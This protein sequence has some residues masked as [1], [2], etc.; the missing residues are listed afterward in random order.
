MP[1]CWTAGDRL[2]TRPKTALRPRRYVK[3]A[4]MRSVMW[5]RTAGTGM[6][7]CA[8]SK[9]GTGHIISGTALYVEQ[10]TPMRLEYSVRCDADWGCRA[11]SVDR[12]AGADKIE[13]RLQRDDDGHWTANGDLIADMNG[14]R[15]IDLGFTPAT[16]T[17]AI[18]RLNLDIKD[19]ATFTAVWLDDETWTFKPLKQRYARLTEDIYRYTSIVSGY[20]ATLTVDDFGFVRTYPNLWDAVTS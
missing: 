11:A 9:D 19:D 15:D 3:D 8:I 5:R 1:P 2:R 13:I 18:K 7:A 14:L 4:I 10:Q 12:W 20:E 16:N 6:E 17:N